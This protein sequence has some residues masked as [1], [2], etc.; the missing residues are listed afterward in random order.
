MYGEAPSLPFSALAILWKKMYRIPNGEIIILL[1][2][3]P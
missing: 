3:A 1:R 2:G